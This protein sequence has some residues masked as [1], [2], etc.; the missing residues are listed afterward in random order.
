MSGVTVAIPSL[1]RHS[2]MATLNSVVCQ[3]H[4]EAIL[5]ISGSC[6]SQQRNMAIEQAL[7]KYIFFTDDDCV[8]DSACLDE[9]FK[10][11]EAENLDLV[12]PRVGGG[13]RS[14][15]TFVSVGAG[16]FA[17]LDL[18]RSSWFDERMPFGEDLDFGWKAFDAGAKWKFV[19]SAQVYHIGAPRSPSYVDLQSRTKSLKLL[20]KK[21]PER[22]QWLVEHDSSVLGVWDENPEVGPG[23]HEVNRAAIANLE[24]I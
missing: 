16:I 9:C 17:R 14:G 11:A 8:L 23:F 12:F 5:V 10:V 21:H 15:P 13:F 2:L 4:L 7:T 6:P 18:A 1:F 19:P 3:K 20:Q 22:F 24:A